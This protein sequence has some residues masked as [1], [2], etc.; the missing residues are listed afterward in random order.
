MS[1][2]D[3][4]VNLNRFWSLDTIGM[5]DTTSGIDDGAVYQNFEKTVTKDTS[6][7]Y[8]VSWPCRHTSK[9]LSNNYTMRLA[10]LKI[11]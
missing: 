6:G 11:C 9:Q 1:L 7:L 4:S 8:V 2:V 10:N 3:K 5:T